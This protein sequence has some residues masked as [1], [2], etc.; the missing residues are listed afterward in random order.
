MLLDVIDKTIPSDLNEMKLEAILTGGSTIL[1]Q[2]ILDIR[3]HFPGINVYQAFGQ[4]E[5]SGII[6]YHDIE[7]ANRKK[8][9][10]DKP[11]SC[12]YLRSGITCKIVNPETE[13]TLGPNRIGELRLKTEFLMNGYH[14]M[15]TRDCYD[16]NG[17]YK[18]G[19]LM[20]Y[21]N[22][23]YFYHIDRIREMFKFRQ[24]H[25][26][27]VLLE[28][29]LLSHPAVLKAAV[30][31]IPDVHDGHHPMGV[32]ILKDNVKNITEDDIKYFYDNQVDEP[33]KLRG[34]VKILK[35]FP[36]TVTGKILKRE[37]L[38]MIVGN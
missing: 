14:N 30:I 29:V 10:L 36:V 3:R 19:D 21:D 20:Y 15:E 6:T 35:E 12:G 11:G 9:M 8:F 25:I 28:D 22:D 13:E 24:I 33:K 27:P 4:T 32:V 7:R 31:G 26:Q 18:T 5:T 2:Q 37:M 34:G 23:E 38:K 17:W 1:E 16:N